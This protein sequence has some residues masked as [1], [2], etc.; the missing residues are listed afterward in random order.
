MKFPNRDTNILYDKL[1]IDMFGW[2][3]HSFKSSKSIFVVVVVVVIVVIYDINTFPALYPFL[4]QL[5]SSSFNKNPLR[6]LS[7]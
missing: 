6:F 1:N 2:N 7:N 3:K 5:S 4:F